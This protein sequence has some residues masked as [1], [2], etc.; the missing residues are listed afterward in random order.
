M[1]FG[2]TALIICNH[3]TRVDWMYLWVLCL[4]QGQLSGLKIVLK[5]SLKG[6]PGFGWATQM[7]LFVFLKRDKSKDLQRVREISD[8]LVCLN[9]PTTLLIFPEG[10]DLSPS[11]LLKSLQFAK[12]EGLAEYQYVLHPKVWLVEES[13][14][15]VVPVLF[16]A[17][18]FHPFYTDFLCDPRSN[19]TFSPRPPNPSPW[20]ACLIL[21][22][23][24][25]GCEILSSSVLASALSVCVWTPGLTP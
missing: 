7:L 15:Y 5:E 11:N 9:V 6:I 22:L 25:E 14:K 18:I 17:R 16:F 10:T 8:Y 1:G 3:R 2:E 4:R 13:V 21:V 20:G 12:K 19:K 23:N 24:E